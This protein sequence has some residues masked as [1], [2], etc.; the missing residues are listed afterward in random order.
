MQFSSYIWTKRY[1]NGKDLYRIFRKVFDWQGEKDLPVILKIAADSDFAV[2]INGKLCP[3]A[4]TA[5]FP[6]ERTYSTLDISGLLHTG[7]NVIAA[8]VYFIGDNFLTYRTG[9]PFFRAEVVQQGA[10]LCATDNSWK[11][12]NATD[13][14]SGTAC[15][16]TMQ[17]GYVYE[18]DARKSI[19]WQELEFDDSSWAFAEEYS[20]QLLWKSMVQRHVP[21]LNYLPLSSSVLMQKGVLFRDNEGKSFA[22]ICYKDA[23]SPRRY[24]EIFEAP[25]NITT[26]D[27]RPDRC[28]DG[29]IESALHFLPVLEKEKA[30]G[31][32][33]VLDLKKE[34]V[35][36]FS[37]KINAPAGTVVDICH[38]EHLNDGRVRSWI[39]HRNFTDRFICKDGMNDFVHCHRRLGCRYIELHI[40]NCGAGKIDLLYAGLIPLELPLPETARFISNDRFINR[41]NKLSEDTLKLC[42]HE[43][44]ED[45]PWREQGLYAYDSRNQILYGYY[46]WGNYDFAA[47]NIDLLGKSYDGERYLTLTSPGYYPVTIPIFTFVWIVEILEHFRYSGSL[48]L[49]EKN[50]DLLDRIIDRALSEKDSSFPQLY[51]P[52]AGKNIWNFCEWNAKLDYMTEYPQA[53][54]NIYLY[55]ALIAAAELHSAG[56]NHDRAEYLNR[57]ASEL[58]GTVEKIFFNSDKNAYDA[59][60]PGRCGEL[61]E[62]IQAIMLTNDLVPEEKRQDIADIFF[63]SDLVKINLSALYYLIEAMMKNGIQARKY[64]VSYLLNI[65]EPMVFSNSSSLWECTSSILSTDDAASLCHGWSCVMPFFCG[66]YI[67]GISPL[68]PG[69]GKFS[70]KIYDAG[71]P[72]VSGEVPTPHGMIKVSWVKNDGK[73]QIKVVH[74]AELTPV[75]SEYEECPVGSFETVTC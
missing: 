47:A 44:Y 66:K 49:F 19:P 33:V 52:G 70:V 24:P 63:R 5:D 56:G 14:V 29:T 6:A 60:L 15:R 34:R 53:P 40:T 13:Y 46:L 62:H 7:K 68:T 74:P 41:C 58:G 51:H 72:G 50:K 20:G 39:S 16:M 18:F 37:L 3:I 67:L 27:M 26:D 28:I 57:C 11:C 25:E 75:L 73:L 10:A 21:Q 35:G 71:L 65:F 2:Y 43:H 32:Y 8:E 1:E 4:Q 36:F 30:D 61:Y 17:L 22:E 42:M 38:G 31:F 69:F 64:L 55:E 59:F 45:C 9:T 48:K 12:S 23:F 54:Y